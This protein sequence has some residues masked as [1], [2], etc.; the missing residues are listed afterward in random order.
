MS[1]NAEYRDMEI[2]GFGKN[3]EQKVYLLFIRI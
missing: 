2:V 3:E 1:V